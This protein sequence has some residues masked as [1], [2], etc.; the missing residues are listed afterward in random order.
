MPFVAK[1]KNWAKW[2]QPLRMCALHIQTVV[3]QIKPGF[4]HSEQKHS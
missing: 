1:V 3:S 4:A 2:K